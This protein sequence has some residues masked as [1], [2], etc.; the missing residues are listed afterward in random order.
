MAD[1]TPSSAAAAAAP[2]TDDDDDPATALLFPTL[3]AAFERRLRRGRSAKPALFTKRNW[4]LLVLASIHA[5]LT[6][7]DDAKPH[8]A[9]LTC[10]VVAH[11]VPHVSEAIAYR[12]SGPPDRLALLAW[13]RARVCTSDEAARCFH[14]AIHASQVDDPVVGNFTCCFTQTRDTAAVKVVLY[15]NR[16]LD[17]RT[18]EVTG[19]G[20]SETEHTMA[21]AFVPLVHALM[22]LGNLHDWLLEQ[23]DLVPPG[24]QASGV[25][26]AS[27]PIPLLD[28][29]RMAVNDVACFLYHFVANR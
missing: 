4:A 2:A 24:A 16:K 7:R 29:K 14:A 13:V 1:T 28:K 26:R 9:R 22:I 6:A 25:L 15:G 20:R 10:D 3:D 12:A 8:R 5:V 18:G 21:L 17:A 27:E 23:P 11:D 19:P